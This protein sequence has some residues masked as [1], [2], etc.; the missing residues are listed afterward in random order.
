MRCLIPAALASKLEW[1]K[2]RFI[3]YTDD[4]FTTKKPQPDWLG[5]LGPVIRAEVGDEIVV[6]FLNRIAAFRTACIAHGLHYDKDNE[7]SFYLPFRQ[8]RPCRSGTPIYL[9][10]AGGCGQ[11]SG[12]GAAEFD[13]VVVSL[14]CRPGIEINAGL[15]GPIIVTAKG[16]ARPDGSPER[17]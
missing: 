12:A 13:R 9:S 16:K 15:I 7:G 1:P 14:P 2:T 3:E 11:R 4:T 6:E 17:R 8:R 5:I 10:L